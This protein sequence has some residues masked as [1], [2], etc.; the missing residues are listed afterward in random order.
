MCT[1]LIMFCFHMQG[2]H[3]RIVSEEHDTL[4]NLIRKDKAR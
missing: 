2:A 3:S 4:L 1:E